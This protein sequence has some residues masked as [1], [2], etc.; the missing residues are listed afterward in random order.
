MDRNGNIVMLRWLLD[1][2]NERPSFYRRRLLAYRIGE[3]CALFPI[4]TTIRRYSIISIQDN[5][6]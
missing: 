5:R 1:M 3:Q 2:L 6:I 4:M